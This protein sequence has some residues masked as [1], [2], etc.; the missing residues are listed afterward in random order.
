MTR[1]LPTAIVLLAI[2]LCGLGAC[3]KPASK[4][5]DAA[6]AATAAAETAG[7]VAATSTSAAAATTA[8]ATSAA[9]LPDLGDF[10]IVQVLMGNAVDAGHVVITDTRE[11]G[12]KDPIYASVLSIGAHQGLKLSAEWLSPDGRSIAKS[13][14]LIVPDSDLATTFSVRNP[15]GW[16]SGDYQLTIAIN[17]HGQH[18]EKFHVH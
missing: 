6:T 16:P 10:K 14:Q 8:P 18:T 3:S 11:F 15:D 12:A 9:P 7:E 5:A 17:G 4:G 1:S 2:A 13:E